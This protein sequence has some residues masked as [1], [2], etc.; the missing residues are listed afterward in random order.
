M[1]YESCVGCVAQG[2]SEWCVPVGQADLNDAG[3][4]CCKV[5][6]LYGGGPRGVAE[7]ELTASLQGDC[8]GVAAAVMHAQYQSLA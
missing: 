3:F 2:S 6:V 8:R 7:E 5:L 4:G 1:H